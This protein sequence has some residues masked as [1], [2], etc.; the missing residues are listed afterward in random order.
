MI[1]F[2]ASLRMINVTA[3]AAATAQIATAQIALGLLG[4]G[5]LSCP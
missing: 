3:P 5:L 1:K 2:D 4:L